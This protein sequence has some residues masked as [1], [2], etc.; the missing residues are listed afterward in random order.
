MAAEFD[1]VAQWTARVA[2]DLG[3]KFYVPAACRG[4]GSPAG[5]D[6]LLD[7]LEVDGGA[8]LLDCGAGMGGPTEYAARRRA[9]RPVLAEPERG[10]CRAARSLFDHPVVRASATA[11]PLTDE[12]FDAAWTLGVLCTVP[13]Q[14]AVL[15]ELRRVVRPGGRIGMLVFIARSTTPFDQ[16]DGNHFPTEERLLG[17]LDEANLGIEA[18]CGTEEL[19][20]PDQEWQDRVKAVESELS[21][22]HQ[23]KRAWQ[24]A[25]RQSDL[26][27]QLLGDCLVTGELLTV[28]RR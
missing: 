10:A 7:N 11:L 28:R 27:G 21:T 12:S 25:E 17:L 1:T 4:S 14:L 20:S 2:M 15:T 24:L 13:D 26:I 5:L 3:P 22:R 16:P 23:E 18:W 6:W 9:V 19:A 8:S